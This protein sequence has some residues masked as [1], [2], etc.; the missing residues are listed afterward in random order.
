MIHELLL[1]LALLAADVSAT[2]KANVAA[3]A[4]NNTLTAV[5][6]ADGQ[7][8][9]AAIWSG[10]GL[11]GDGANVLV[12]A[13][14]IVLIDHRDIARLN[15]VRVDGT[16][17]FSP[18]E[19]TQLLVDTLAVSEGGKL[20]IGTATSPITGSAK[21]V[22][23]DDGELTSGLSRGLIALG[24]V[25]I[26]GEPVAFSKDYEPDGTAWKPADSLERTVTFTSEATDPLRRG[27][28]MLMHHADY[29]VGWAAFNGLG[30]T[31]KAIP[32]GGTNLRGRYPLHF[33][34]CGS[35]TPIT[36]LGAVVSGSNGWG[37]VNHSSNV[38]VT[39]SI[40][41]DVLGAGFVTESGNE[42]GSFRNC[43]AVKSEGHS[44]TDHGL[45]PNKR[46]EIGD[47]G[48]SG[49]GF[50]LQGS[51]VSV[52]DCVAVGH[53]HAAFSV[54]PKAFTE[55]DTGVEASPDSSLR[56][57]APFERNHAAHS[58][59]GHSFEWTSMKDTDASIAKDLV[60]H[61]CFVGLT[62]RQS[63]ID[64]IGGEF[65]AQPPAPGRVAKNGT[66]IDMIG[67]YNSEGSVTGAKITGFKTGMVCPTKFP[68]SV[69][70]TTFKDNTTDIW[71]NRLL[72]SSITIDD[73]PAKIVFDNEKIL[74]NQEVVFFT[75]RSP[76]TI[77][78][79]RA[80]YLTQHPSFVRFPAGKYAGLTNQEIFDRFGLL[81]RG[82]LVPANAVK[83]STYY[84]AP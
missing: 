3:L 12:P 19:D 27:H 32:I 76:V 30:R 71:I 24:M 20:E 50:W 16:L 80:W 34:R 68:F 69:K 9:N 65:V 78:G 67:P 63:R 58:R 60:S 73:A 5:A 28:V 70:A 47:F 15:S 54:F 81:P 82:E 35:E 72:E 79:K 49:H 36:V 1:T 83:K 44:S 84:L 43:L 74:F 53:A 59:Y 26:H 11:P 61:E 23:I 13:G 18:T 39:D 75:W 21:I 46:A 64:V 8:D 51:D 10:G 62:V 38:V 57:I 4:P 66:G 17:E 37:L 56:P 77:N 25:S 41:Y 22:F 40:T 45:D 55:P 14:R 29:S 52:T 33:H 6:T 2:E 48:H 42:L 7:W 31:N